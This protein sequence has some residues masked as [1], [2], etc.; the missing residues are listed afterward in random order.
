MSKRSQPA[1]LAISLNVAG[2]ESAAEREIPAAVTTLAQFMDSHDVSATWGFDAPSPAPLLAMVTAIEPR[3]EIALVARGGWAAADANRALFELELSRRAAAAREAG[4][5]PSTLLVA[6][7]ATPEHLDLVEKHGISALCRMALHESHSASTPASLW[8]SGWFSPNSA[9]AGSA[10]RS[11]R[12]GLWQMPAAIDLARLGG[13]RTRQSLLRRVATE[14][15]VH[16]CVDVASLVA[17]GARAER[18]LDAVL[19]L[20]VAWQE[21]GKLRLQSIAATV[22]QLSATRQGPP[23]RSILRGAA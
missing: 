2:L 9:R 20:A 22:A 17:G 1:A 3:Q 18:Q 6:G 12:W 14:G 21:Q 10:P 8:R 7:G 13:W 11:L 4:V 5:R 19:R 16:L 15:F 23:A